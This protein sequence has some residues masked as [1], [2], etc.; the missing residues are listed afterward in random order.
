VDVTYYG[1]SDVGQYIEEIAVAHGLT[2]QGKGETDELHALFLLGTK[3]QCFEA[4]V[5]LAQ[6]EQVESVSMDRN[7]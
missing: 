5:T 1:G 3:K 4:T 6:Y 7:W 2:V